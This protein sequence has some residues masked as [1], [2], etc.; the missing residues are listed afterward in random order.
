MQPASI[1]ADL[2]KDDVQCPPKVSLAQ[3]LH[4]LIRDAI[5]VLLKIVLSD[6]H[7]IFSF[8]KKLSVIIYQ[9]ILLNTNDMRSAESAYCSGKENASNAFASHGIVCTRGRGAT[10]DVS[11]HFSHHREST[12]ARIYRY[13]RRNDLGAIAE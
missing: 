2:P 8:A 12:A 13:T 3:L 6:K 10:P 5:K 4:I 1:A 9:M 11:I 7:S